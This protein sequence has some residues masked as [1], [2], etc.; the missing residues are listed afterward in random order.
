MLEQM[1]NETGDSDIFSAL[2]QRSLRL[3]GFCGELIP[4]PQRRRER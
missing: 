2:S 4:K 1:N 3:C